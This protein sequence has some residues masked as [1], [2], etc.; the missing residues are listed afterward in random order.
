MYLNCWSLTSIYHWSALTS[1]LPL[2]ARQ[3]LT[4]HTRTHARVVGVHEMHC[5]VPP[6]YVT[7]IVCLR[8][9][10]IIRPSHEPI[11]CLKKL[12]P[13]PCS[14]SIRQKYEIYY[15]SQFD[16]IRY[17]TSILRLIVGIDHQWFENADTSPAWLKLF[18]LSGVQ[19]C[20]GTFSSPKQDFINWKL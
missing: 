14:L 1:E 2:V 18:T 15:Y 13:C 7:D 12:T 6:I 3:L 20:L 19:L 11:L 10:F 5:W 16:F 4:I 9:P 8:P 17:L